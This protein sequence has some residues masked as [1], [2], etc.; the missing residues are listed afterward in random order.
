MAE[1]AA[2]HLHIKEDFSR[3]GWCPHQARRCKELYTPQVV[4]Y[5]SSLDRRGYRSNNHHACA[6][7][8]RCI[9]N[10]VDLQ[11]YNT[12]HAPSCPGS[13]A[14]LAVKYASVV[15]II[16]AGGVPLV[17][18]HID[19]SSSLDS[20]VLDLR[21]TPRTSSS[22]YTVLS[23]VWFDGLGN[24]TANALPSCQIQRMYTQ[25]A[26]LPRDHESG[27]VHIAGWEVDW[28]RQSFVRHPERQPPLF[29]MD[30]LCIPVGDGERELRSIAINQMASIYAA[31]VHEL[32]LDA[33]LLRCDVS[34][35][36]ATEVLA[37]IACSAWMTR[38]WTLQEGVLARECVFQFRDRAIDPV[39][40]WCLHG[41]RFP[42][43]SK[44]DAALFP[45]TENGEQ[46]TIYKELYNQFW[47][48]LHQDWKSSF[49]RDP[50]TPAAYKANGGAIGGFRGSQAVGKVKTL[51]AAQGRLRR[52]K[53]GLD[54][55]DH[56]T[57]QLTDEHRLKQLVDTW[58]EL[59]HRS[60]TMPEDLHVIIANLLD[61]N[62]DKVMELKT[63]E[64]R[65]RAI[66][67]SFKLLPVS[68]FWNIGPKWRDENGSERG[69]NTWIPI[70]PSK[71]ELTL[72]PVMAVTEQWLRLDFASAEQDDASRAQI[73]RLPAIPPSI[74]SAFL[75]ADPE[76]QALY[77]IKLMNGY[78]LFGQENS[79]C[80]IIETPLASA[81]DDLIRGALFRQLPLSSDKSALEVHL[82]YYC[83]IELRCIRTTPIPNK[84]ILSVHILPTGTSVAVKYGESP[85]SIPQC[86]NHLL[87]IA[88]ICWSQFPHHHTRSPF[89]NASQIP[90]PTSR[91]TLAVSIVGPRCKAT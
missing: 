77:A 84:T 13:C 8:P 50:P 60:T 70:E 74:D 20:P 14:P 22:R 38:S 15:S 62:A 46:W 5:L 10:N 71:S 32:V 40:E 72:T 68:L 83:P 45:D 25:L 6:D 66:I 27:A 44:L 11:H 29:W 31:A 16:R 28:T 23:H 41:A 91:P 69:C 73:L 76:T 61:F 64:D 51:P 54:D 17:S 7:A 30:T 89:I 39:H 48:T 19:P 67:L 88:R 75:I 21:V 24:P 42:D 2:E 86:A 33:E 34:P 53:S 80:L 57:M 63:R 79:Y 78:R 49:R 55:K 56:F 18:I 43:H 12:A 9:A 3:R 4:S 52:S 35:S 58:N 37:R 47:D 36:T 87:S 1:S 59:A 90:S 81:S 26:S 82:T 65:M 85:I